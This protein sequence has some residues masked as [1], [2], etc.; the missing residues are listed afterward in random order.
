[1][2]NGPAR[3]RFYVRWE[4]GTKRSFGVLKRAAFLYC[5]LRM[6]CEGG[7]VLASLSLPENALGSSGRNSEAGWGG[8][9]QKPELG[10]RGMQKHRGIFLYP[11]WAAGNGKPG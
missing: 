2:S 6:G 10:E 11:A 8:L 4:F 1:M 5:R 7:R 9:G 3:R